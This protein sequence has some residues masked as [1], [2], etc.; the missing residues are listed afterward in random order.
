MDEEIDKVKAFDTP[1]LKQIIADE[2]YRCGKVINKPATFHSALYCI[3]DDNE[4]V[5]SFIIGSCGPDVAE[6]CKIRAEGGKNRA[7][8][9][10]CGSY[11][12]YLL[13]LMFMSCTPDLYDNIKNLLIEQVKATY[14]N[15]NKKRH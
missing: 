2:I 15:Y 6:L 9:M 10:T 4:A 13:Q 14:K 8:F 7:T 3:N 11:I 12:D 1:E 5:M